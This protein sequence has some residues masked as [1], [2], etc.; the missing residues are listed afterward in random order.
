MF[1]FNDFFALW[2]QQKKPIQNVQKAF[3]GRE[4]QKVE[5]F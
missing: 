4:M 3:V 1:F 5:I 2:Q